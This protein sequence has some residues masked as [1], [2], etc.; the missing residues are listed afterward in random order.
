MQYPIARLQYCTPCLQYAT[1]ANA[2]CIPK[3]QY[4]RISQAAPPQQFTQAAFH[5]CSTNGTKTK[6]KHTSTMQFDPF[7]P[8]TEAAETIWFSNLKTKI[9]TTGYAAALQLEAGEATTVQSICTLFIYINENFLPLVRSFPEAWTA[10]I[11]QARSGTG[12]IVVPPAPAWNPPAGS[13]SFTSGLLSGLFTRI[14]RWKTAAGYT[15]AIGKDLGIVGESRPAT[16]EPPVLKD[17]VN[18][19][20]VKLTFKKHGHKGIYLESRRQGHEAW[21]FLA[22]DIESPYLDTRANLTP[23]QAEWREYRARYWDGTAVGDWSAALRVNVG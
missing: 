7:F 3:M 8:R 1:P 13:A 14:A 17:S 23:G 22:I 9:L 16:E 5:I 19:D 15:E 21:E 10:T 20:G 2:Y 6:H 11:E 4:S 18:P 12:G